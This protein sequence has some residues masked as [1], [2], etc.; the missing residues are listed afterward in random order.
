MAT[1]R[2]LGHALDVYQRDTITIADT[3]AA[4]DT[5]TLT[6]DNIDFVITIGSLVTTTQ[7]ATT[8]KEAFNGSPSTLTD[9]TASYTNS[10]NPNQSGGATAIPQF[11]DL[12]ASSSGAVVSIHAKTAGRPFTLS[13]TENTAGTGTATEATATA[14]TGAANFANQDN[15]SANTVPVDADTVSL[16]SGDADLLYSI[17]Q[18][19]VSPAAINVTMGYSGKIGLPETNKQNAA[20][21]YREYLEDYLTMGAV[22]DAQTN[23]I[24]IGDGE[25]QGSQRIKIDTVDAQTILNVLNSG[26]RI[27]TGVPAVLWKGT[28]ASN[29]ANIS[30]GDVGIAALVGETATVATLTVAYRNNKQGDAKVYCGTGVTLTTINQ[31]GGELRTASN[32]VTVNHFDGFHKIDAGTVTTL[33]IDGGTVEYN[34]TGTC[35][36]LKIGS[37]GTLDLSKGTGAVTFTNTEFYEGFT[38]IDP[39]ARATFTNGIDFMRCTPADGKFVV[40][41]HRTWTP[42]AI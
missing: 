7:V 19:A 40:V 26:Q 8:I 15:W 13:V 2:W 14:A 16:G 10:A 24:T 22:A 1:R 35:T 30:K 17:S 33:N 29:V 27:E 9:T 28:H 41:P 5:V 4:A 18:A 34:G 36:N 25:G 6:I 12:E 32:V 21:P 20:F 38:F 39:A 3:W 23:T 11:S 37:N 42:T 31:S